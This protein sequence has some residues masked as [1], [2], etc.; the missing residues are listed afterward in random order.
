MTS[1]PLLDVNDGGGDRDDELR[2]SVIYEERPKR[3]LSDAEPSKRRA[4]LWIWAFFGVRL[5]DETAFWMKVLSVVAN[6][7]QAA[8][9]ASEF[10]D[11]ATNANSGVDT[12]LN[13]ISKF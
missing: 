9:I 10:W 4:F 8:S 3:L 6:C 2:F 13:G 5:A 1:R 7:L 12:T 11:L